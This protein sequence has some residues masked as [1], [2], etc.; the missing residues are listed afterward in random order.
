MKTILFLSCIVILINT[1]M[2]LAEENTR[3]IKTDE[4]YTYKKV[5][6]VELKLFVYLP[7]DFTKADKRPA[8]VFYFGGGWV[9]GNP[10]HFQRQCRHYADLGMVAIAADYRTRKRHKTT[11]FECVADAKS[12]MRWIRSHAAELGIDPNRI[13]AGGGSAGGH[14]ASACA[15]IKAFDDPQD[16]TTVSPVPAALVLF[17]PVIDN[18][19]NGYGYNRIKEKYVDFSPLHNIAKGAPPTLI[20]LGDKDK[21]IPVATAEDYKKKMQSVGSECEVVI[22]PN[23]GHGFFNGG[24]SYKKTLDAADKFLAKLGYIKP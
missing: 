17:N 16:D 8:I 9:N 6:D 20:L 22:F 13:V 5:G 1:P 18:G 7:K 2:L 11:P 14:L 10:T 15:L 23:Q 12:A 4:S 24:K 3:E 19:T 21:L